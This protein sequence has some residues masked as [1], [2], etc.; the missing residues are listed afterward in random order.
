MRKIRLSI[1][2]DVQGIQGRYNVWLM[3]LQ[4]YS[5]NVDF[6]TKTPV[7]RGNS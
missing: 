5:N 6:A 1:A 3:T 4:G 2:K 7:V